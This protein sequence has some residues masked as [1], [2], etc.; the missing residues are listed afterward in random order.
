M[1]KQNWNMV[2]QK[3]LHALP[4]PLVNF[5]IEKM[6]NYFSS[7]NEFVFYVEILYFSIIYYSIVIWIVKLFKM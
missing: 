5:H 2:F 6:N 1:H 7:K 4:L 3:D